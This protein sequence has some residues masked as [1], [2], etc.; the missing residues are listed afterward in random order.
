MELLD[1]NV[2]KRLSRFVLSV[3]FK[4]KEG[5]YLIILGRS[6]SGKSMT[7]KI[8]AG[9]EK[10]DSG[11]VLLKGK[12]IT[13]LP[14]ERRKVAYLFQNP[15]LFPHMSVLENLEFPYRVRGVK[16]NKERIEEV[17]EKFKISEILGER[18]SNVSGGEA[19]RV[20]LA[21]AVLSEPELLILDEPLNQLDFFTKSSLI[22][23]LKGIKGERTVIHITHDLFEAMALGDRVI[24]I[25]YGKVIFSGKFSELSEKLNLSFPY[26]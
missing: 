12:N 14:P 5:E 11:R 22:E 13:Y 4:V 15:A 17:T 6:G 1:V 7:A 26:P 10:P 8:I 2:K 19:Q 3:S 24:F 9:I 16:P 25:E 23:F 20:A 21:R 18:A